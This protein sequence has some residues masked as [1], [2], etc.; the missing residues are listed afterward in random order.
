VIER[1]IDDEIHSWLDTGR[2]NRRTT[3]IEDACRL[4]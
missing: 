3:E 4:L 2:W 1:A